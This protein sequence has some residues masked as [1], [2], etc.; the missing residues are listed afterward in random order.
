[1]GM[2]DRR[3]R[4]KLGIALSS[5]VMTA[6]ASQHIEIDVPDLVLQHTLSSL[7]S[8]QSYV[9]YGSPGDHPPARHVPERRLLL[10]RL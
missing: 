7:T 5:L 9:W 8:K 1:M 4:S 10:P 3:L 2:I 6:C